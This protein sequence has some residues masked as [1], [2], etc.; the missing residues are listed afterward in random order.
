MASS[1]VHR[2]SRV[3]IT[4]VSGIV[5]GAPRARLVLTSG[6]M[7][8]RGTDNVSECSL[9]DRD[10]GNNPTPEELV[11]PRLV[12]LCPSFS[13]ASPLLISNSSTSHFDIT[14]VHRLTTATF[15][16]FSSR[17]LE[18]LLTLW[19][20]FSSSQRCIFSFLLMLPVC[21]CICCSI[22]FVCCL[23][24]PRVAQWHAMDQGHVPST[25]RV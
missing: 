15:H 5:S 7:G 1:L 22:C 21:E 12:T 10:F 14:C 20:V 4:L 11:R 19:L 17:C 16:F 25:R 9:D 18:N 8:P 24:G 23:P 3:S 13:F 2:C 6:A